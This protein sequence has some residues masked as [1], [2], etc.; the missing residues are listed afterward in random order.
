MKIRFY[1]RD[2]RWYA[3]LPEYIEAGGTEEDCEMIL[4]SDYWLDLLALG[5]DSIYIKLSLNPAQEK[6]IRLEKDDFGATY[7]VKSYK[8]E[9]INHK[10][11]I[12]PV[13]LFLF[14]EYPETIY[15]EL[16]N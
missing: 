5:R 16:Y 3:D 9:E 6:I 10:I 11:W 1:C 14:G 2:G 13:T 12:C 7:I 4:G 8:G 15:Y